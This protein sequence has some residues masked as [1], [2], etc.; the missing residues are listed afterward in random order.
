MIE[1]G[2][3][4]STTTRT[5]PVT[6]ALEPPSDIRIEPGMTGRSRA[7]VRLP[8]GQVIA[9]L[10]VPASAVVESDDETASIWVLDPTSGGVTRRKVTLGDRAPQG[11]EIARGVKPGEWVAVAGARTLEEGQTVEI[12]DVTADEWRLPM[13]SERTVSVGDATVSSLEN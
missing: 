9:P 5:Y 7:K 2:N 4:A 12:L 1:V 11:I 10:R 8:E 13:P 3:E 6:V